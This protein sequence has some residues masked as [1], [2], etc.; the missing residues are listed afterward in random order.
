MF[1]KKPAPDL[2]RGGHRFPAFAEPASAGEGRSEAIML[3]QNSSRL[4][5]NVGFGL[6]FSMSAMAMRGA[7]GCDRRCERGVGYG[8]AS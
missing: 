7:I 8:F 4:L 1:P 2:I 3:K 5:K 6:I